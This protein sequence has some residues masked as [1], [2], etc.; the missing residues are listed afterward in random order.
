M[1]I[2]YSFLVLPFIFF[3]F[4]RKFTYKFINQYSWNLFFFYL[5]ILIG[6]RDEV[7]GDWI[8]YLKNYQI[9]NLT[10]PSYK[11]FR[12][13]L[14][15]FDLFFY[16]YGVLKIKIHFLYLTLTT[17][18]TY[19]LFKYVKFLQYKWLAL[20]S[21]IP[22]LVIVVS[23]GYVKQA[24]AISFIFLAILYFNQSKLRNMNIMLI[25]A[26]LTHISASIFFLL[27]IYFFFSRIDKIKIYF[28]IGIF[29][30]LFCIIFFRYIDLFKDYIIYSDNISPG[31]IYRLIL[32]FPF[33]MIIFFLNKNKFFNE[34]PNR[35]IIYKFYL[36]FYLL[37]IFLAIINVIYNDILNSPIESLPNYL[38]F[39]KQYSLKGCIDPNIC[40]KEFL[41]QFQISTLIDRLH[42]YLMIIYPLIV[43]DLF[44]YLHF[45][46][47]EKSNIFVILYS[48]YFLFIFTQLYLWLNF[49]NHS[50]YWVPFNS[51]LL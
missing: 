4:E 23:I 31:Y 44:K 16:I 41:V 7:G 12:G 18:F 24:T 47:N 42:I 38:E 32:S 25:F 36:H 48:L 30:I 28:S 20:L 34:T 49:A 33:L 27:N 45:K 37:F 11:L 40:A 26:S 9:H 50:K 2:Y 15:L 19:C 29:F 5:I 35:I 17:L 13:N 21:T 22:Y 51:V 39:I 8:Q 10:D 6:F 3:I 14:N 46:Y 43:A 1:I